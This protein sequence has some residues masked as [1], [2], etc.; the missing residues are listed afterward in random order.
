MRECVVLIDRSF[1]VVGVEFCGLVDVGDLVECGFDVVDGFVGQE[2]VQDLVGWLWDFMYECGQCSGVN[3][4]QNGSYVLFFFYWI[5]IWLVM[6]VVVLVL[7][8]EFFGSWFLM[9]MLC[10]KSGVLML[11]VLWMGMELNRN[12][13]VFVRLLVL[14]LLQGLCWCWL[15]EFCC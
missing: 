3:D 8:L 2:L 5:M 14:L 1:C 15:G 10:F 9:I 11:V 6:L 12:L 4:V 7:N 13:V